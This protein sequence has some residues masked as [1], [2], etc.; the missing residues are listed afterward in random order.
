MAIIS[1]PFTFSAGATII[2]SQHNSNFSTIYNDYNGNITTSN[3]SPVAGILYS[4]LSLNG[5]ITN[6]DINTAANIAGTKIAS[7]AGSQLTGNIPMTVLASGSTTAGLV[8]ISSGTSSPYASWGVSSGRQFFS[9]SAIWTAPAGVTTAFITMIGGGGAGANGGQQAGSGGGYVIKYPYTV[10]SGTGYTV[11]VG[12]GGTPA[13][14]SGGTTSFG[15]ISAVGGAAGSGNTASLNPCPIPTMNG[16][17]GNPGASGSYQLASGSGGGGGGGDIG[18]GGGTPFGTGGSKSTPGVGY[19][20]G[21]AGTQTGG[22][23]F[24]LVEW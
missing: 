2:A 19:G 15:T 9:S 5:S 11:T 13:G 1:L 21:G 6:A 3:I 7:L 17:A 16:A 8:I 10:S 22:S 14:T 12:A 18:G 20:W 24:V 23:G 4:Q